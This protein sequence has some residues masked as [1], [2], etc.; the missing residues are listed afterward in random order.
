MGK[1]VYASEIN[2][3]KLDILMSSNG[4]RWNL[5]PHL[6][7]LNI[8]EN[9]FLPNLSANITLTDASNLPSILPIVG[10]EKIEIIYSLAGLDGER[11]NITC[12][13]AYTR[14]KRSFSKITT[15]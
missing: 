3:E 8:Y 6:V 14:F 11:K 4:K 1:Q 2:L 15:K 7:E 9:I 5:I 10:E 12:Y 13:V